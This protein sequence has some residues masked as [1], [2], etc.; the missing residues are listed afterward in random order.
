[1]SRFRPLR[2]A[3]LTLALAVGLGG[4]AVVGFVAQGQPR[5][6]VPAAGAAASPPPPPPAVKPIRADTLLAWTPG[7]L[8]RG[9]G[10]GVAHLRGVAH[11]VAMESDVIWLTR[12]FTASGA[13]ADRPPPG[14][15]I[16][17]EVAAASPSAYVPFLT[18]VDRALLPALAKGQALLGTTSA[19]LRHLGVGGTLHFGSRRVTVGGIVPDAEIG[20]NEMF[21]S[22]RTGARLG[23]HTERYLLIDP[24]PH[25]SRARIT[26]GVHRLLP[27]GGL[28]QIRG[29]GETPYFRQGD[30]VLPQ[31]RIK[32]L[33]GEFASRPL[34]G[35]ELRLDPSWVAQHIVTA[36]VPILGR[37]TC[38]RAIIPQL[39]GALRDVR[40]QGLAGLIDRQ[41]F[42]GCFSPRYLNRDPT[43]GISHHSWGIA[44]DVNALANPFGRTPHQDARL[45]VVFEKWGFTWGGRWIV[46]DGMHFEFLRFPS[47]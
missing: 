17:L 25:A 39:R 42:A 47:G 2:L 38:N 21:V 6:D 20:A 34:A 43:A 41:D 28:V 23:V 29:P 45:V 35:G 44:L 33:F 37:V 1:V 9:F 4:G 26:A 18:P 5:S 8:P 22:R 13:V 19:A 46:P 14:L 3:A 16:P 27:P 36:T 7:G 10:S 11:V 24:K 40:A 15:A 12:S 30:A 32:Q 31:V